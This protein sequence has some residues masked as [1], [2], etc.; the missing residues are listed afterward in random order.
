[1][2]ALLGAQG[3][4]GCLT[5]DRLVVP[6]ES[7]CMFGDNLRET[8]AFPEVLI[9]DEDPL[10]LPEVT[11]SCILS[12]FWK[13]APDQEPNLRSFFSSGERGRHWP[14]AGPCCSCDQIR[15]PGKEEA[16]TFA[17]GAKRTGR[18]PLKPKTDTEREYSLQDIEII[19]CKP[20][21]ET[22][23]Y[24]LY[25]KSNRQAGSRGPQPSRREAVKP[26]EE[27]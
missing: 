1:M 23:L 3:G 24:G 2:L 27:A 9:K 16:A 13:R 11:L 15:F 10:S 5:Q 22:K 25:L 17:K 4:N 20:K 19:L 21:R 8:G 7:V 14:P 12:P 26:E 18:Q 6:Q